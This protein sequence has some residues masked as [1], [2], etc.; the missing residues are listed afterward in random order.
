MVAPLIELRRIYV[1][2][3]H[4]Q[5]SAVKSEGLCITAM[6]MCCCIPLAPKELDVNLP[7][8]YKPFYPK[9]PVA[10]G[11]ARFRERVSVENRRPPATLTSLAA[12][13]EAGP[14]EDDVDEKKTSSPLQLYHPAKGVQCDIITHDGC[15][16]ILGWALFVGEPAIQTF[17]G[18]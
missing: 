11:L 18:G 7:T 16:L 13:C 9:P 6:T 1:Q 14:A 8:P 12:S 5:P 3:L 10:R 4:K 2:Q 15:L 17:V